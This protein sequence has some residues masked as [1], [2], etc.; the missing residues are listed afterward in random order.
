MLSTR[1]FDMAMVMLG[2]IR[3]GPAAGPVQ[4]Q[5]PNLVDVNGDGLPDLVVHVRSSQAGFTA[6]SE[7]ACLTGL[8]TIGEAVS[9]CQALRVIPAD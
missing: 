1:T 8:T 2:S 7:M 3:F 9:G 5:T 6:S 4:D